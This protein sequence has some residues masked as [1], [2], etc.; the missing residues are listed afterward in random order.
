MRVAVIGTG[1]V[2]LVTGACLAHVGHDVI[3]IDKDPGRI[4]TLRRGISPIHEAGLD[5][6]LAEGLKSGR[7]SFAEGLSSL[8]GADISMICVGTP[9]GPDGIDLSAIRQAA[10]AIGDALQDQTRYHVVT[11]KSTVVPGTTDQVVRAELEAASGRLVGTN[12]GLA[13]NPEFLS[14]GSAVEDLLNPDRIIIGEWDQRSGDALAA[15][16]KPFTVPVLRMGLRNAEMCKY[17]ANAFQATLIS[18]ANQIATICEQ[19]PGA[20]HEP[21][22]ESVHLDRNLQAAEG[23]IGAT[24]FLKGGIGF[25]GSCFPKDLAA[26]QHFAHMI[27][28]KSEMIDA[29]LAVNRRRP[30]DVLV[31][32][33]QRLGGLEGRTVVIL[34]LAFKPGTDDVRE[35][36]GIALA[37]KLLAAGAKVRTHDPLP[38]ARQRA[39]EAMDERAGIATTPEA[40]LEGADAAVIA[41]AWPH[42]RDWNWS[43]LLSVMHRP[44]LYDGRHL[45]KG[46]P[47]PAGTEIV[48][49]GTGPEYS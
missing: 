32:L 34:G 47:F 40:A 46:L 14:Q 19:I 22:I 39:R 23:A 25:G 3:C 8:A 28:A 43:A 9:S 37:E 24:R 38:A 2:G 20:D 6:L 15:L 17:A 29:A 1:Y 42:Y 30:D 12:L 35:S 41:T 13:M 26:L 7:L 11:V 27:G 49:V 16:Y 10:A 5:D 36:P 44:L 31:R 33:S 21:V 48:R 45:L 18:F 4:E